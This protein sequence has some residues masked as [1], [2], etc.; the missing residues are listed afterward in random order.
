M[1]CE[2]PFFKQMDVIKES[3]LIGTKTSSA[4]RD[5]WNTEYQD[6][7]GMTPDLTTTPFYE[8]ANWGQGTQQLCPPAIMCAPVTTGMRF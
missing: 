3:E 4:L 2:F 7:G 5:K 6:L 8:Y 1:I